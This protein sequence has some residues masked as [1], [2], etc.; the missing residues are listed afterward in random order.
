MTVLSSTPQLVSPFPGLR[1]FKSHEDA[2]FFGRHEQVNDMLQRLETCRLLTVVGASGCGKSSLVR[3]GLLPALH[4]GLLFGTGSE[5]KMIKLRPGSNPYPEL[6]RALSEALPAPRPGDLDEWRSHI[7][8]M[9][10]SG[11]SG[12]IR[13]VNEAGLPQGSNVMVLV[14][15]FEELFRFRSLVCSEDKDTAE[16]QH[17]TYEERNTANAFVNLLLETIRRQSDSENVSGRR[18]LMPKHPIFVVLTMR[19]EFLGHCD[20]FLGL[21]EAV[22]QSQFLTPRMTREQLKD[23]IVRPLQLFGATPHPALVNRI[24]NDVGTDPDSLPLM[25]HALLRTWQNAKE[26]SEKQPLKSEQRVELTTT[27]YEKAGGLLK[28]LSLHADEA[29]TELGSDPVQ[30]KSYRRIA[31]QLFLLLCRQTGEG[32]VVRNPIQVTEAAATAGVSAESIRHVAMAFCKEGR[33]FITFSS[34]DQDL[35]TDN[36]LDISHESLIRN[37]DTFKAWIKTEMKSAADYAWLLKA[38]VPS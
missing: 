16:K 14:D 9:L 21:P 15:Q 32:V 18:R 4:E 25:Q 31:Q 27:D 17:A 20:A 28:A 22:S 2:I 6:A 37:W 34:D 8:A 29:Y 30:G 5:W 11:D 33:N 36:T 3:A 35:R 13:V 38:D 23:A 24:L 19:S 12:L 26:R 7:Q 1:P 10:L